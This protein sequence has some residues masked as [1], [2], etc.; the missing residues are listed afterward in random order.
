VL[1]A[2]ANWLPH[3]TTGFKPERMLQFQRDPK[4]LRRAIEA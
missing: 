2:L 4:S 3:A 1:F